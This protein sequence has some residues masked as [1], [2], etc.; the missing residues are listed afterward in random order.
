MNVGLLSFLASAQEPLEKGEAGGK[1]A[2]L[3]LDEHGDLASWVDT[4]VLL[5]HVLLSQRVDQLELVVDI[6][7][8]ARGKNGSRVR[9]EVV[10]VD[11]DFVVLF[12]GKVL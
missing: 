10:T 6:C 1:H 5:L 11:S 9:T 7:V 8:L 12:N 4:L 2:V 3:P